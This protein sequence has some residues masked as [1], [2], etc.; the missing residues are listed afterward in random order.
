MNANTAFPQTPPNP[1]G[2]F[3]IQDERN[4]HMMFSITCEQWP[5][6][7]SKTNMAISAGNQ[8]DPTTQQHVTPRIV[9]V[10]VSRTTPTTDRGVVAF[11]CDYTLEGI[12]NSGRFLN[13]C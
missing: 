8:L 4:M 7:L 3:S 1:S 11:A 6:N 5:Q 9:L 2:T 10:Y 13:M 12:P